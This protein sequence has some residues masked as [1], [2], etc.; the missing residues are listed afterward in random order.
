MSSTIPFSG[1]SSRVRDKLLFI[2]SSDFPLTVK[3]LYSRIEREGQDVTYQAVHKVITQLIE[4]GIVEKKDKG[5]QLSKNWIS[6]VKDYA[7]VVDTVYTKGKN[8]IL[9]SN[10]DAPTTLVFTDFTSYVLW[11]A[12][13]LRDNKLTNGQTLPAY[14]LFYH[15]VWP[16]RFNFMDFELLRQMCTSCPGTMGISV[17]DTPFDRW[18]SKHYMLGGLGKFKTGYPHVKLDADY[19]VHGDCVIKAVFSPETRKFMDKIYKKIHSLYDLF[20]FYFSD[21]MKN[22][23][24]Y[25]EVTVQRSPTMA[26]M[27]ENQIKQYLTSEK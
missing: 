17:C 15:A 5:V 16:L 2:L 22:E 18:V 23:N 4:E 13:T 7:M 21:I 1:G 8:Q 3:Q 12:E 9:P 14:G 10:L 25:I 19:F 26:R 6:Q 27:I 24:T 20:N 11:M